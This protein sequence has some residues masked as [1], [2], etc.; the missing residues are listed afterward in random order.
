LFRNDACDGKGAYIVNRVDSIKFSGEESIDITGRSNGLSYSWKL[1]SDTFYSSN[2]FRKKFDELGCFPVQLKVK[3]D[4][5]GRTSTRSVW[6]KVE[7]EKPTLSSLDVN[8]IDDSSDPVIVKVNALGAQDRDGVIQSYLWYYY[9]D[10]DAE[11]QDFRATKDPETTFV[12]PK[13]TGNYY[14]VVLMKDNNEA[15][16]TSEEI[17][18]SKYFITLAGDNINTPLIKLKANKRSVTIGEEIIF[19]ASAENILGQDISKK[20]KYSWD[21]DGDGFYEKETNSPTTSYKFVYS[22]ETHSKVKVKYK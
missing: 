15:R 4:K 2:T 20:A 11:P 1:D 3:S 7:N 5:N 18:G 8:V 13:I 19:T 6:V 17:T 9:T 10:I 16:I 21:L 14:F 12:L 22:G